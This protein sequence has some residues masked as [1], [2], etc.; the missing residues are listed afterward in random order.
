MAEIVGI[1]GRYWTETMM[2]EMQ[3]SEEGERRRELS[4]SAPLP[5]FA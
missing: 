4:V 1:A 5:A 3:M 2:L